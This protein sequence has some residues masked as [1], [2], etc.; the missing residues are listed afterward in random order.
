MQP[1]L[2]GKHLMLVCLKKPCE[3]V[4][5]VR[6]LLIPKPSVAKEIESGEVDR[7]DEVENACARDDEGEEH[8]PGHRP[9]IADLLV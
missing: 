9:V 6:L 8:K 1:I 7:V 4:F 5:R 3:P 2:L